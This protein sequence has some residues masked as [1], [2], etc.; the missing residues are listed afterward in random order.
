MIRTSR[1]PRRFSRF[2]VRTRVCAC[3][4]VRT[5]VRTE[6]MWSRFISGVFAKLFLERRCR[7]LDVCGAPNR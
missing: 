4:R 7:V 5:Y 1:I 6:D 3:V 2:R